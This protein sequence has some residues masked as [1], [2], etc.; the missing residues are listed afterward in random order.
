MSK[1]SIM[2]NVERAKRFVYDEMR[3][4]GEDNQFYYAI[5]SNIIIDLVDEDDWKEIML[6]IQRI[7]QEN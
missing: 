6:A 2:K 3:W 1:K 4:E 7:A 5:L